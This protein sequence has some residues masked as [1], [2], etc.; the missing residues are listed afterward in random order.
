[1]LPAGNEP[2]VPAS[3]WPHTHT[4]DRAATGFNEAFHE[5]I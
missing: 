5:L 2:A 3:D 4:L 1:M